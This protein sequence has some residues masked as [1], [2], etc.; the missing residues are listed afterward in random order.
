MSP[1]PPLVRDGLLAQLE[2]KLDNYRHMTAMGQAAKAVQAGIL[3][4]LDSFW[5]HS[6]GTRKGRV[7]LFLGYPGWLT[8]KIDPCFARSLLEAP[9]V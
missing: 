2:A 4:R 8:S 3:C 9:W 6:L 1:W 5:F 7:C